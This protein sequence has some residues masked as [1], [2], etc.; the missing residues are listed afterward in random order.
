LYRA[1]ICDQFEVSK[2]LLEEG[3]DPNIPN[4]LGQ[5]PLHSAAESSQY[6]IAELLLDYKSNPNCQSSTGDTPLHI[7]VTKID[8]TMAQ[9]LLDNNAFPDIANTVNSKQLGKTTL[10]LAVET[11]NLEMVKLVM[12]Y[13]ADTEIYDKKHQRPLDLALDLRLSKALLEPKA[14][15]LTSRSEDISELE[16]NLQYGLLHTFGQNKNTKSSKKQEKPFLMKW[17]S[18]IN[19]SEFYRIMVDSGYDDHTVMARQMLT[20]VPITENNLYEIGIHKP[21]S[22]KKILFYLEEEGKKRVT[23]AQDNS[24]VIPMPTIRE[25]LDDLELGHLYEK[26]IE[27]GYDDYLTL[28][29]MVPTKWGLNEISLKQDLNISNSDHIKKVL[30]KLQSD[31]LSNK[32][33]E[34]ILYEEPKNIACSKCKII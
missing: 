28:V 6:A 11:S 8:H 1:V 15:Y 5:I 32:G 22:R 4:S 9:L 24:L 3:A 17:L 23:K 12:D 34:M 16:N 13:G 25:W 7:A 26:F 10:H 2:T 14:V 19:L 18:N 31:F 27:L 20:S 29:K 33:E 21:G 30:K